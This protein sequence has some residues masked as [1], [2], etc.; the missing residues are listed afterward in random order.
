MKIKG[1]RTHALSGALVVKGVLALTGVTVDG[2][3]VR[4]EPVTTFE[5]FDSQLK[6]A[7]QRGDPRSQGLSDILTGGALSALRSGVKREN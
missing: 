3:P 2:E 4:L 5:N 6:A 1:N 7:Q